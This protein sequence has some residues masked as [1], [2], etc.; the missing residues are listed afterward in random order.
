MKSLDYDLAYF[1]KYMLFKGTKLKSMKFNFAFLFFSSVSFVDELGS[2]NISTELNSL[3]SS[4]MPTPS[5]GT[6]P[7]SQTNSYSQSC[8]SA[9]STMDDKK[10]D[11]ILADGIQNQVSDDN[12]CIYLNSGG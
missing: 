4:G 3:N 7:G 11:E 9:I 2:S 12:F 5:S 1:I 6:R 10:L 8:A